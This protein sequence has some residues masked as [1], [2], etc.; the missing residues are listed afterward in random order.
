VAAGDVLGQRLRWWVRVEQRKPLRIRIEQRLERWQHL[1]EQQRRQ[2]L[3][4]EQREQLRQ[5]LRVQ[6]R[7]QLGRG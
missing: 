1:G 2:P 3:G 7:Q 5:R 6:Q 4:L